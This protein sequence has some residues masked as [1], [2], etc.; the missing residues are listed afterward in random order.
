[1]EEPPREL[2]STDPARLIGDALANR[3]ELAGRR[4]DVE[5]A[6]SLVEAERK[7]RYPAVSA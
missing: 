2:P 4:F 3:P 1:M 6:R 7:L 5:A